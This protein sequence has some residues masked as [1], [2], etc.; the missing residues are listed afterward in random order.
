[1]ALSPVEAGKRNNELIAQ[2]VKKLEKIIDAA[3]EAEWYA[4]SLGI[5]VPAPSI[6]SKWEAHII[7]KLSEL[8]VAAGWKIERQHEPSV[9]WILKR[10]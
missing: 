9:R 4:G 3:L 8:Y 10:K 5:S 1:M 2:E 7:S 6:N